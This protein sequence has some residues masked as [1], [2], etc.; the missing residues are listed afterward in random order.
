MS[1]GGGA[2]PVAVAAVV[3]APVKEAPKKEEKIEPVEED[4]GIGGFFDD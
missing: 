4:V 2:A 1:F 3:K